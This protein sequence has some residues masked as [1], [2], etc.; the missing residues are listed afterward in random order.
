MSCQQRWTSCVDSSNPTHCLVLL[1]CFFCEFYTSAPKWF[2]IKTNDLIKCFMFHFFFAQQSPQKMDD[3]NKTHAKGCSQFGCSMVLPSSKLKYQWNNPMFKKRNTS[4]M[5][6]LPE[7]M[8]KTRR[9]SRVDQSTGVKRCHQN[10]LQTSPRK[11]S[12]P[13]FLKHHF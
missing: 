8:V 7:C 12:Q 10:W 5:L 4:S 13:G 2:W 9:F 1:H 11:R 6:V 3:Y